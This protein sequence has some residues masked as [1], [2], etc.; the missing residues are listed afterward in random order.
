MC[1]G[2]VHD[3]HSFE[4]LLVCSIAL[5]MDKIKIKACTLPTEELIELLHQENINLSVFK[6][7][8]KSKSY[9]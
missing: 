6:E 8:L 3:R 9:R 4:Q 2:T 7:V 1:A 5:K